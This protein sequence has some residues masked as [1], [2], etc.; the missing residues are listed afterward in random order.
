MATEEELHQ[1]RH[2]KYVEEYGDG[3]TDLTYIISIR[4]TELDRKG[5]GER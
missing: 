3:M 4:A 2:R 5:T 1:P